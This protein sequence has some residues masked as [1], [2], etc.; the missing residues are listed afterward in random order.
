MYLLWLYV[1][2]KLKSTKLSKMAKYMWASATKGCQVM[3]RI[4]CVSIYPA[5]V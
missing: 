5:I 4:S 1:P 3:T 2:M